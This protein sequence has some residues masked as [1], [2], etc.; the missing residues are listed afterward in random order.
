MKEPPVHLSHVPS[1]PRATPGPGRCRASVAARRFARDQSGSLS[2]EAVLVLPMLAWVLLA[3]FSYFDGL[4]QANVN[5]KAAHTISDM[6]SRETAQV[7]AGYMTGLNKVLDFLVYS[8]NPTALRVTVARYDDE[9]RGFDLRWSHS[10]GRY[11]AVT[12]AG[13][14]RMG[15]RIPMTADGAEVILVETWMDYH[16]P[17]VF[18]LG[19]QEIYNF[20]VTSSRF[21]PEL[22]GPGAGT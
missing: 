9:A 7:D 11:P 21:A 4:R 20:V 8:P 22:K 15:D 16:A 19:D 5:I 18:G 3:C 6:L 14:S 1:T 10:T 17:F 13:L 12:A 2:I